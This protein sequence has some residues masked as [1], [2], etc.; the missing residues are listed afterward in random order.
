MTNE[1]LAAM[2]IPQ[3]DSG[4]NQFDFQQLMNLYL[5]A[6]ANA[7]PFTHINP[8]QVLGDG[9]QGDGSINTAA[10]TTSNFFSNFSSPVES[11]PQ[12]SRST[13]APN[14]TKPL[15]KTVGGKAV[16]REDGPARSNS[17]PNLQAM[18]IPTMTSSKPSH[19]RTGSLATSVP[20]SKASL[21]KSV[22]T[23]PSSEDTS[24]GIGGSII[25][26]GEMPTMCTN[27]QTTNTPLW[28]R[29]PEGQPLCNA[30]GLF[31][32]S[33]DWVTMY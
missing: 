31:Y 15:P 9:P 1:A 5:N 10:T 25:S 2:G 12:A 22:P 14:P 27:C 24:E 19:S 3:S 6:N 16:G 11:S 13:R 4:D 32:V 28:R 30:C 18:R 23:T 8:S 21:A 29:D 17:S 33:I 26:S 7:G 20:K